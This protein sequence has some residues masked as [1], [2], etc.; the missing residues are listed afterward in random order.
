VCWGRDLRRGRLSGSQAQRSPRHGCRA[1]GHWHLAPDHV[2]SIVVAL[3]SP[4][5][6]S[7]PGLLA[8]RPTSTTH[9]SWADS[10]PSGRSRR[11]LPTALYHDRG[12]RRAGTPCRSG[13]HRSLPAYSRAV[14][15]HRPTGAHTEP[16]RPASLPGWLAD[17]PCRTGLAFCHSARPIDRDLLARSLFCTTDYL[18]KPTVK[19]SWPTRS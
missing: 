16:R 2:S 19:A 13:Q 3:A 10:S 9:G 11:C 8:K 15:G 6:P 5:R 14:P 18:A 17:F 12:S 4:I 1:P 7:E